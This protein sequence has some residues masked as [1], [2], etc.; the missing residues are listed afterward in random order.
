MIT[1]KICINTIEKVKNFV[2]DMSRV[3]VPADLS[4]TGRRYVVDAKSILGILSLDISHP[5]DLSIYDDETN[6]DK[7]RKIFEKYK[8]NQNEMTAWR[9]KAAFFVGKN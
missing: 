8:E 6:A 1:K 5:M 2:Q 9:Q 3:E 7:Y 4:N